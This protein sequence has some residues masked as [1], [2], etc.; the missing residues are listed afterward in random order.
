MKGTPSATTAATGWSAEE[1]GELRAALL[2]HYDR[3]RRDLPWRGES[4]PYRV[5]VSEVM[6]QQT[7]AETVAH[8]YAGWLERF[9][10][11]E[12]LAGADEDEVLKAWEGLGY[13]R[14]ARNLRRA[15]L[16]ARERPDAALPSTYGELR[17]LPGLG[18]YTAGAVASIAF[19][20]AVAAADGNVRRVM[21]RLRN[22][23]SPKAAWLRRAAAELLDHERPGDWNQAMMELGATICSPRAPKCDEC[24][25]SRWCAARA[26]GTQ[27]QRPGRGHKRA[28]RAATFALAVLRAGHRVLLERRPLPGLLGGMWAFPEREIA[29]EDDAHDAALVLASERALT[30]IG[31]LVGLPTCTHRF[32]HLHATYVPWALEVVEPGSTEQRHR[33]W[34]EPTRS[35]AVAVPVAQR[36]VLASLLETSAPR[37]TTAR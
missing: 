6:L 23:P 20:E 5:L 16:L 7:R 35:E 1:L 14:R 3:H 26:A 32:T 22:V 28:P 36:R 11:L 10:D 29:R 12:T 30:P 21:S 13:Y 17:Q 8:R 37:A 27:R 4:D 24:P 15:A 19:G 2:G 34:I 18:E 9:P 31:E 33:T 25:V